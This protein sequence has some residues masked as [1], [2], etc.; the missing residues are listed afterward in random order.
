MKGTVLMV[1][2][3]RA[4]CEMLEFDLRCLSAS[5]SKSIFMRLVLDQTIKPQWVG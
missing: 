1:D 5:L 3:D 4:M 2:D